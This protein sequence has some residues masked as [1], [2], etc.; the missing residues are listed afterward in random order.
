M[1]RTPNRD[2]LADSFAKEGTM[3][4][5]RAMVAMTALVCGPG[6]VSFV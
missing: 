2:T 5:V 4:R 3:S 6:C 1:D